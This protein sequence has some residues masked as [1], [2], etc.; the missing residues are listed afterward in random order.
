MFAE[1]Y[2]NSFEDFSANDLTKLDRWVFDK[3]ESFFNAARED[4]DLQLKLRQDKVVLFLHLLGLDTNGHKNKPK[5]VY[6][7]LP[8]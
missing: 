4:V 6:N 5:R 2:A 8:K 7:M 3:V 1:S